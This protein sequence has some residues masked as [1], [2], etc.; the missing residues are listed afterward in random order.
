MTEHWRGDP[1]HQTAISR[2]LRSRWQYGS[3]KVLDI[4]VVII[5]NDYQHGMLAEAK[6]VSSSN[7][8]WL[9]TRL[10]AKRLGFYGALL[11][12]DTDDGTDRGVVLDDSIRAIVYDPDGNL[13]KDGPVDVDKFDQWVQETFGD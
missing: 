3:L 10:L 7:K 12:Y 5:S 1:N 6:H 13:R 8:T 11:I 2:W 9:C 4:D